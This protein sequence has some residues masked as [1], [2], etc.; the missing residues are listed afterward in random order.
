M[1]SEANRFC[2]RNIPKEYCAAVKSPTNPMEEENDCEG[3]DGEGE[4][5]ER[6][7]HHLGGRRV[8]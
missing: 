8:H 3:D 5:V 4:A 6:D 7:R 2:L 1:I